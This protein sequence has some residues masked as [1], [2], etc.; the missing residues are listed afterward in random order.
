MSSTRLLCHGR[1]KIPG[2]TLKLVS[3]VT[4]GF[5]AWAVTALAQPAGT[6]P[7][8]NGRS[9][10]QVIYH[11][12]TA[13]HYGA[14]LHSQAKGQNYEL[15]IDSDMPTSLQNSRANANAA[16][17]QQQTQTPTPAPPPS[18]QEPSAKPTLKANHIHARPRSFAK[19]PGVGN[20]H[21][22]KSHKK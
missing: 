9:R 8:K 16:A 1:M 7:N 5:S 12:P 20:S 22:S 11:L 21:G 13:S 19:P 10:P 15:P 18:L 2:F 17:Q 4:A 3:V 6:G 14:T